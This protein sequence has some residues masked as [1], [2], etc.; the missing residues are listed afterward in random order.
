MFWPEASAYVVLAVNMLADEGTTRRRDRDDDNDGDDDDD[1]DDDSDGG[2]IEHIEHM[3]SHGGA[4][5]HKDKGQNKGS[6]LRRDSLAPNRTDLLRKAPPSPRQTPQRLF[7]T[8]LRPRLSLTS[9]SINQLGG[10]RSDLNAL[11]ALGPEAKSLGHRSDAHRYHYTT[12]CNSPHS[13][14][15]HHSM[16]LATLPSPHTT[17]C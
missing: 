15:I 5:Q 11:A 9:E 8:P 10:L 13:L 14:S 7:G 2:G 6:S 1:D 3:G 17:S 16:L 4:F 12:S